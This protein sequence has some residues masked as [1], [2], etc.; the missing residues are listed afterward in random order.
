MMPLSFIENGKGELKPPEI[1]SE[2]EASNDNKSLTTE[3]FSNI[4][5]EDLGKK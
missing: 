4:E 5:F 1:S 3:E 2:T